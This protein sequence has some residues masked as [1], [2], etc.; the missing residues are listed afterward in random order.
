MSRTLPC[1]ISCRSW[2]GAAA[3]LTGPRLTPPADRSARDRVEPAHDGRS[4]LRERAR[5]EDRVEVQ[6]GRGGRQEL[7]EGA[8]LVPGA[9]R[10]L[11]DEPVGLVARAAALNQG[12]QRP[13]RVEGP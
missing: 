4:V 6:L 13:L 3:S 8:P 7:A 1:E 9:L 11:L 2:S 5:V 10:G 12:Q